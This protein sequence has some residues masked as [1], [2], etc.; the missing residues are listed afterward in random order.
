MAPVRNAELVVQ[1]AEQRS[2]RHPQDR[3]NIDGIPM[4]RQVF[5]PFR[6]ASSRSGKKHNT[7][8]RLS[9]RTESIERIADTNEG[10]FYTSTLAI[11]HMSAQSRFH[12]INFF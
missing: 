9:E 6:K 5:S 8:D 12:L 7:R 3:G 1:Q 2:H 10:D 11:H 4:L